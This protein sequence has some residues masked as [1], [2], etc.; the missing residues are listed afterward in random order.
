MLERA[1]TLLRSLINGEHKDDV[2]GTDRGLYYG[3]GLFETLAVVDSEP[4]RWDA[5]LQ[6]LKRG[7][8]RLG[9]PAIDMQRLA[10]EAAQLCVGVERGV[11]KLVLT[12]G[13]GGRGYRPPSM[14]VPTRILQLYSWPAYPPHWAEHGVRARVCTTRL[15]IQP[16]LAGLKHLNRLE[17][18]LARR[19]WDDPDIAEGLMLD[20]QDQII[21]GTLSNVFF[22]R[23]GV[24][25]TPDLSGCGVAGVTRAT[26]LDI[27]RRRGWPTKIGAFRMHDLLQAQEIFFCNSVIGIWPVTSLEGYALAQ[28]EITAS[29]AVALIA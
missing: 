26:I 16:T 9:F 25:H 13:S 2:A 5:H 1:V 21:S 18:V 20:T 29:I 15:A 17:Q 23:H 11:L 24:L 6:R 12:R 28:G 7:M 8:Q 10:Q 27:A 3:D 19:E 4:Q 14:P 22:V